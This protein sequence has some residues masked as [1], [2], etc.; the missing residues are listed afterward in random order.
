M[1]RYFIVGT[2]TDCG[3][4]YV[5]C[6]LIK[7]LKAKNQHCLAIKPVASGCHELAD[8]QLISD[9]VQRL[10]QANGLF[11]GALCKWLFKPPIAPH[12]AAQAANVQLSAESIMQFCMSE[13]FSTFEHLLI[14]GAGGLMVPLNETETWLDFL[15][16]SQIPVILVVG[17]RLGCINHA[18]LTATVLD[19]HQIHCE[20][21]IANCLEEDMLMLDSNVNAIAKRLQCPLLGTIPYGGNGK[22]NVTWNVILP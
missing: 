15:M 20:G 2:D 12:L 9:D 19:K 14:E 17:M 11:D 1:K 13:Q 16:M 18:L 4:T 22:S 21:W 10:S 8:G 3:K 5:T 7:Q 6:Q